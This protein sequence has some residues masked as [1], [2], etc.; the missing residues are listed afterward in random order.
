[1]V[2]E[3]LLNAYLFD[4][5]KRK[6]YLRTALLFADECK[7][8][9]LAA[10]ASDDPHIDMPPGL[11]SG[12]SSP[13]NAMQK[14][15]I[16]SH[17]SGSPHT[18]SPA[19]APAP[20]PA[21][22][23]AGPKTY[24]VP[25]VSVPYSSPNGFLSEWWAM[26]W[27]VY[28]STLE[29][30]PTTSVSDA[31][32]TYTQHQ[33]DKRSAK[34]TNGKRMAPSDVQGADRDALAKRNRVGE[35]SPLSS[36]LIDQYSHTDEMEALQLAAGPANGRTGPTIPHGPGLNI[37]SAGNH[38]MSDDYPNFLSRSRK[39]M[40]EGSTQPA[41]GVRASQDNQPGSGRPET[42]AGGMRSPT[43]STAGQMANGAGPTPETATQQQQQQISQQQQLAQQQQQQQLSQQ[44]Q[45][46]QQTAA[47]QLSA[48]LAAP[49]QPAMQQTAVAARQTFASP[50]LANTQVP[51]TV[52]TQ[53]TTS[54]QA[55]SAMMSG[56]A[57]NIQAMQ[58]LMSPQPVP[59]QV[60]Q[61]LHASLTS[62][63][64][65][66]AGLGDMRHNAMA[67]PHTAQHGMAHAMAARQQMAGPMAGPMSSMAD[68]GLHNT[69]MAGLNGRTQSQAMLAF[70]QQQQQMQHQHMQHQQMQ[71]QQML[72]Q[73]QM[74]A[75]GQGAPPQVPRS[76]TVGAIGTGAVSAG[77]VATESMMGQPMSATDAMTS[78]GGLPHQ[79][80]NTMALQALGAHG[81]MA[82]QQYIMQ[83]RLQGQQ[84]TR[85]PHSN[86]VAPMHTQA[87]DSST[88]P[89]AQ[90]R[91]EPIIPAKQP[92]AAKKPAKAKAKRGPKK[93][94]QSATPS[95]SADGAGRR[96][97]GSPVA[98][99]EAQPNT[100]QSPAF[101]GA[102]NTDAGME[103]TEVGLSA[104]LGGGAASGDFASA[105][106]AMPMNPGMGMQ[107][108]DWLHA[109]DALPD[110][111][112]DSMSSGID[113]N[114]LGA[115]NMADPALTSLLASVAPA[116]DTVFSPSANHNL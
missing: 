6:G 32:R 18:P 24:Q 99:S 16:S 14:P 111:F 103:F 12:S 42:K 58:R 25:N 17:S 93:S 66:N 3:S 74:S 59:G 101:L 60:P 108:N 56:S 75:L 83:M 94:K 81:S 55:G 9:P 100:G 35:C 47:Q 109:S 92:A 36:A 77:A 22:M 76:H 1:M 48:Q 84:H 67:G 105:I 51:R 72:Q 85:S 50:H 86:A 70:V 30:K 54:H 13:N 33:T 102:L 95:V 8:L 115:Y 38:V 41:H 43:T 19:V 39:V 62:P 23:H 113:S 87:G 28:G 104:L 80:A 11:V 40:T 20:V 114:M 37:N 15:D 110:M 7:N 2:H 44:Q 96:A 49:Q 68:I 65:T 63:M 106:S 29:R 34:P 73:Q 107:I 97:G 116:S 98:G 91:L 89:S 21:G 53:R 52:P 90:K 82:N 64:V 45:Q 78:A 69:A 79:P 112:M 10:I 4:Y 5:L 26:F 71:H 61:P 57:A 31:V 88:P 27:D 46:Q